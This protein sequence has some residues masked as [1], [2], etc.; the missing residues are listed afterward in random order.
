MSKRARVGSRSAPPPTVC[1][2]E[3]D[4]A[5]GATVTPS[6]DGMSCRFRL[7][8]EPVA[9][10]RMVCTLSKDGVSP[11][12]DGVLFTRSHERCLLHTSHSVPVDA[13]G[14]AHRALPVCMS[15][16]ECVAFGIR[17]GR[18]GGVRGLPSWEGD[19]WRRYVPI[20]ALTPGEL[21]EFRRTGNAP[22][23]PLPC[24]LCARAMAEASFLWNV[25]TGTRRR[26]RV[27]RHYNL[28][29]GEE[30][31][32]SERL[33]KPLAS[34]GLSK[35]L[36]STRY[37][38]LRAERVAGGD[39]YR[40][41][42][43]F[44][45][46]PT[47]GSCGRSV[48]LP[49]G[50]PAV[51]LL[52]SFELESPPAWHD[53]RPANSGPGRVWSWEWYEALC[54]LR[55]GLGLPSSGWLS[56]VHYALLGAL[57]TAPLSSTWSVLR[58]L[59]GTMT[60]P[61]MRL[62][63][64][65]VSSSC[66]SRVL[67]CTSCGRLG[68][69]VQ[70][71]RA[72]VPRGFTSSVSRECYECSG[73]GCVCRL[74]GG[75]GR[76]HYCAR[77]SVGGGCVARVPMR[78]VVLSSS[79][80]MRV[81]D[82]SVSVWAKCVR[83][84]PRWCGLLSLLCHVSPGVSQPHLCRFLSVVSRRGCSSRPMRV[85]DMS[86]HALLLEDGTSLRVCASCHVLV[87]TGSEVCATCGSG[88]PWGAGVSACSK[89]ADLPLPTARE[90]RSMECVLSRVSH[91][92]CIRCGKVPPRGHMVCTTASPRGSSRVVT[93]VFCEGCVP[94]EVCVVRSCWVLE[95]LSRLCL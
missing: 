32:A 93:C 33:L 9:L 43:D 64:A 67:V 90:R 22:N 48:A 11:A 65:P 30:G 46:P 3:W 4:G 86:S 40:I 39:Y 82:K 38:W 12:C 15:G 5:D 53:V 26:V 36:V 42:E 16:P 34:A 60:L 31:Y 49:G 92:L 45:L 85:L 80:S 87:H 79:A 83:G 57:S 68:L 73:R 59:E 69:H 6:A 37:G 95:E 27:C 17:G 18:C 28:E 81:V 20:A 35:H 14:G 24:L 55:D 7:V 75:L 2:S 52:R 74:C 51:D 66:K 50:S 23:K 72:V 78:R 76:L 44:R 29:G 70:R 89:R 8:S 25:S 62:V 61:G 21:A 91:G 94:V 41:I 1:A 84:L 56:G 71:G 47:A 54:V 19:D 13:Y 88:R 58:G 63:P 77:G 10:A